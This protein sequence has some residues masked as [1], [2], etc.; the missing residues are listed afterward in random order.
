MI[1]PI[2]EGSGNLRGLPDRQFDLAVFDLH[3]NRRGRLLRPVRRKRIVRQRRLRH[4]RRLGRKRCLG[5]KRYLRRKGSLGRKH[6]A[7]L[8]RNRRKRRSLRGS[9]RHLRRFIRRK[10]SFRRE[11]IGRF[12]RNRRK[13][14]SLYGNV[15]RLHRRIRRDG[16]FRRERVGQFRRDRRKHRPL[17]GNVR[18]LHRRIRRKLRVFHRLRRRLL[19]IFHRRVAR[20]RRF[21]RRRDCRHGQ[22]GQRILDVVLIAVRLDNAA[23][24]RVDLVRRHRAQGLSVDPAF[25]HG[26][27]DHER[28]LQ[29][30]FARRSAADG[31]NNASAQNGNS[32]RRGVGIERRAIGQLRIAKREVRRLRR[33][34]VVVHAGVLSRRGLR[35]RTR[36]GSRLAS[37]FELR[38]FGLNRRLDRVDRLD[39]D[40][41]AGAL[42][43]IRAQHGRNH[44]AQAQQSRKP[45]IVLLHVILQNLAC[46]ST[47]A[48]STNLSILYHNLPICQPRQK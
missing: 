32:A 14:R 47:T 5:R 23:L 28:H 43:C 21:R 17:Y 35:G 39:H 27:L 11:H 13:H 44:H 36:I 4:Q 26:V 20:L 34:R 22:L 48:K 33:I 7:R 1:Q 29:A 40:L 46:R 31:Q 19:R 18:R 25:Q 3:R 41:V 9:F 37:Q 12:R 6:I 45:A 42:L 8:R 2:R 16:S 30:I 15:R 24:E 38:G 10:G